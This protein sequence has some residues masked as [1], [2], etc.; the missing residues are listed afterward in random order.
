M[1]MDNG[2]DIDEAIGS[3]EQAVTTLVVD[4]LLWDVFPASEGLTALDESQRAALATGQEVVL[5]TVE[6]RLL[7]V[8]PPGSAVDP[9]GLRWVEV[10]RHP[11]PDPV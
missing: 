7:P 1:V 8:P 3:Q 9:V 5:Y 2:S 6:P 11:A 10:G 4:G